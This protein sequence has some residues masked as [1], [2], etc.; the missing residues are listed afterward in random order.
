[1][2]ARAERSGIFCAKV[3]QPPWSDW[4]PGVSRERGDELEDK[5]QYGRKRSRTFAVCATFWRCLCTI[6]RIP[7]AARHFYL[8][9]KLRAAHR[10]EM[11]L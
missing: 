11:L 5:I 10:G 8:I 1:M 6:R 9:S 2:A 7:C 4:N 3:Q